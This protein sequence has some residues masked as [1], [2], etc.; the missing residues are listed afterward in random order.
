MYNINLVGKEGRKWGGDSI[1]N[2]EMTL[3]EYTKVYGVERD[4]EN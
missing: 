1:W 2:D 3:A 4:S